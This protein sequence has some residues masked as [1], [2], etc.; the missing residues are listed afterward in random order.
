MT[1]DQQTPPDDSWEPLPAPP[2]YDTAPTETRLARIAIEHNTTLLVDLLLGH[3]RVLRTDPTGTAVE[4]GPWT[5]FTSAGRIEV[6]RRIV[7]RMADDTAF[8]TGWVTEIQWLGAAR[9]ISADD[10]VTLRYIGERL[11]PP[12]PQPLPRRRRW[13]D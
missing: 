2:P 8:V 10:L 9:E 6:G 3:L 13:F 1:D 4:K 11:N 5:P 7:F 12:R